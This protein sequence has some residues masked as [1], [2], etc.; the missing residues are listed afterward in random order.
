MIRFSPPYIDEDIIKEVTNVLQSGWL[1]TGPVTK[2]L[3]K[4]VAKFCNIGYALGVN[5][6]TSGM[7][8]M[9][10][11]YGIKQGDEV[12]VPAYTYCATALAV[13][14]VGAKPVMVDVGHDFNIDCEKI[15]DH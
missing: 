8:L 11:W 3:E 15:K 1:T 2:Q 6:A 13:I 9:L 10:H 7:M 14:H 5:S 4:E 12:I